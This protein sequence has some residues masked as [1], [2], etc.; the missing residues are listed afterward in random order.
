[1]TM[2]NISLLQPPGY[3]HSMALMDIARLLQHSFASL[4]LP[5]ALQINALDPSSINIVLG[6]HL[7][8]DPNS[9]RPYTC[10]LYQLEQLPDQQDALSATR[11]AILREAHTVWDYCP[12]NLALLAA[13]GIRHTR[14]L[15]IGF[16]EKLSVI[17]HLPADVDVLFYGSVND[18]RRAVLKALSQRC[19]LRVLFGV[20]GDER[21]R[22]IARARIVLNLH[23]YE[24]RIMEQARVSYLLNNGRFVVSEV[25]QQN[26]YEG[27]IVTADYEQL[28]DCCLN[29]LRA[30]AERERIAQAGFAM[31]QERRMVAYLRAVLAPA[32]ARD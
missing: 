9:L 10:I 23:Y 5:C 19:T 13:A 24:S 20:Y 15:P 31:F 11:L 12:E 8:N 14:L 3:P 27:G 22:C 1:M 26:P 28:V 17:P 2:Y 25:S 29:Y 18:R 7:L 32:A 21:D 16:H 4:Q 30:P 6:Y